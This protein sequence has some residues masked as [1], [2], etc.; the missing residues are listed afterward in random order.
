MVIA[1]LSS[2]LSDAISFVNSIN[3]R[4][5]VVHDKSIIKEEKK[6]TSDP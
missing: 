2:N 4:D 3:G 5:H 6:I 1:T